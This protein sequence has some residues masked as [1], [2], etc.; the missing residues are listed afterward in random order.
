MRIA[1]I[2]AGAMGGAFGARLAEAGSDVLLVDVSPPVVASVVRHGVRLVEQDKER[3]VRVDVTAD[4]SGHAATDFVVFFVKNYHT[5]TAARLAAPLVDGDTTVV[6]LQNGWGNGE[7][8]A[9]AFDP[10]RI[11][12]GV[13]YHS[14]TIV[15]PG[16]VAHTGE[17]PT[18]VGPYAA[19]SL[20]RAEAFAQALRSAGFAAEVTA[21]ARNEIW[22]K[23]MLNAATLPAAALTR[24]TARA[25]GEPG[26]VL[27]LV[28]AVAVEAIAIAN[29][30]GLAIDLEER[31]GAIHATLARAGSGKPSMLQDIEA[32]RR[33]EI[34][35]ITG[36][37]VREAERLGLDAP[38][39]KALYALV[40][41]LERE[42][43]LT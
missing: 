12:V 2:G 33:T 35:V 11:V 5:E 26:P 38:L 40:T 8:L 32:N 37:V 14:A 36:A 43:G 16:K 22:K 42:L 41:G 7:T 31:L 25:L 4:P 10:S 19:G 6:S 28:D 30:S 9:T 13:T 24:L 21:Q 29:A 39:N 23:L 27:D 15:E 1:V 18:F 17:G 34:D 3:S 20:D